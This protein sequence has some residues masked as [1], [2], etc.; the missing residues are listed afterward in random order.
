MRAAVSSIIPG[1][2]YELLKVLVTMWQ[3]RYV[4]LFLQQMPFFVFFI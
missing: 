2:A 1:D 3:S 4:P